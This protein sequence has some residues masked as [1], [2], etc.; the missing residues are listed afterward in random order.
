M[1]TFIGAYFL[2]AADQDI[3][4]PAFKRGRSN[5]LFT[6][7]IDKDLSIVQFFPVTIDRYHFRPC[8]TVL[9]QYSLG[10][11]F[12]YMLF[13]IDD[14]VMSVDLSDE[15]EV[16]L[17]FD[18]FEMKPFA[19]LQ[20][21]RFFV[22]EDRSRAVRAISSA[23][24]IL[25]V[26]DETRFSFIS[27]ETSLASLVDGIWK[28]SVSTEEPLVPSDEIFRQF[29]AFTKA[30][31]YDLLKDPFFKDGDLWP[32][33]F[34]IYESKFG[35]DEFLHILGREF[36]RK[37]TVYERVPSPVSGK[38]VSL[39][40]EIYLKSE[41]DRELTETV[42]ELMETDVFRVLCNWNPRLFMKAFEAAYGG[43]PELE[44]ARRIVDILL[45]EE[46]DQIPE[47]ARDELFSRL[48]EAIRELSFEDMR[49]FGLG[50]L[51]PDDEKA[52]DRFFLLMSD[53][54]RLSLSIQARLRHLTGYRAAKG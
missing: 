14:Q 26:D 48:H 49:D 1:Y 28:A 12:P 51:D 46:D 27:S 4:F 42:A 32:Y 9:R 30:A 16:E 44:I 11:A 15:A 36:L 54:S 33:L 22:K 23:A 7:T 47:V 6:A 18:R 21:A 2:T 10:D 41:Y 37:L 39:I 53:R 5:E 29:E 50:L 31:A 34:I 3:G 38:V 40:I 25:D 35:Y 8:E 20:L 52:R 17:A 19:D 43:A 24:K 45:L 13:W